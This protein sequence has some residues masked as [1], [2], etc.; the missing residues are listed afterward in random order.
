M[1]LS[2]LETLGAKHHAAIDRAIRN[3]LNTDAALQA[4][5]Q[6]VD[7]IP[8]SGVACNDRPFSVMRGDPI[9]RHTSLCPGALEVTKT[10]IAEFQL[11]ILNFDN[12]LLGAYQSAPFE[13]HTFR[14]RLI[15]LAAV[16]IHQIA[17]LLYKRND[18]IHDQHNNDPE[19]SVDAVTSWERPWDPESGLVK[20]PVLPTRFAHSYYTCVGQYPEG[21]ADAVG[22]WAEKKV[23]GGVVVFDRSGSWERK[24]EDEPN[25]YFHSEGWQL[26][27]RIWRLLDEQQQPLVDFLLSAPEA[28]MPSPLPLIASS[29]NR[30]RIDPDDAT[31]HKIYRDPWERKFL[32]SWQRHC[33]RR[34]VITELDYP[35]RVF[36]FSRE[37]EGAQED[38]ETW[39]EGE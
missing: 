13:E 37:V 26:T 4:F 36:H 17:V 28:S 32:T 33:R 25:A 2:T 1:S 29:K 30:K 14:L 12:R 16:A 3:L 7:G 15:E 39:K 9:L 27:F 34:C 31:P 5:A 19:Y 18:R 24:A 10:F 8:L 6:I 11:G 22:Y 35:E 23:F 38:E 20:L 21:V